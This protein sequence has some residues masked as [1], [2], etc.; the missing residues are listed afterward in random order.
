MK[1]IL[2]MFAFVAMLCIPLCL[3]SCG[4]DD[5]PV[6]PTSGTQG[7][8]YTVNIQNLGGG[9]T[10]TSQVL[11]LIKE[12]IK[13]YFVKIDTNEDG[14]TW[15]VVTN[16]T[17]V[18][19]ILK[20]FNS[21]H[22][23]QLDKMMKDNAAIKSFNIT[24]KYNLV[25][26]YEY[27]YENENWAQGIPVSAGTYTFNDDGAL[28]SFTL[29]DE[30]AGD[31]LKVGS[32]VIPEGVTGTKAGTYVGKWSIFGEGTVTFNSDLKQDNQTKTLVYFRA[33]FSSATKGEGIPVTLT[34]NSQ[35]ILHGEL[36][37]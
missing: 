14:S 26:K 11:N 7:G 32:I 22:K 2:S 29:T 35:T 34:F 1:K 28:W 25:T 5:D 15:L 16:M 12:E 33:P 17:A 37:K 8:S 4:D 36:F 6:S 9:T 20:N 27:D 19:A 10:T 18:D 3:V 23:D 24:I 31:G 21:K 13:D 30:D